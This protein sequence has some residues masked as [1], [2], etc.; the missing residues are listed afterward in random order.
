MAKVSTSLR[1][2]A[3]CGPG[4]D[5]TDKEALQQSSTMTESIVRKVST[6][7]LA[8]APYLG[9]ER[10]IRQVEGP[11]CST[12]RD[13]LTPSVLVFGLPCLGDD[14]QVLYTGLDRHP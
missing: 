10:V 6:S 1:L 8:F 2:R 11:F 4:W 14:F 12:V 5:S 3:A 13:Q 9:E 7:T